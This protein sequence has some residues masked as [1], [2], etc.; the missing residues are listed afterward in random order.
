MPTTAQPTRP[1]PHGSTTA[2]R[3]PRRAVTTGLAAVTA[4]GL[5]AGCSLGGQGDGSDQESSSPSQGSGDGASDGDLEGRTV[6]LVTH[7]SFNP[8]KGA[9]KEFTKDTGITVKVLKSGDAGALTNKL[10]L[11]KEKPLGDVVFGIDNTFGGRAL[12]EGVVAEHG[13]SLPQGVDRHTIETDGGARL[14]P[15]DY[16]DV[17]VNVDDTWFEKKGVNPPQGLDDLTK[18]GYKGLF[19]TPGAATSSPGLAFLLATIGA[20]GDDGWEQYWKDLVAN[21]AKIT[22]GW[23]DAYTVDFTAGG[24]KGDRPIVLSYASSPPFTVPEGG[25]EPTT[26]ALLDTCFRQVEYA[27]VLEG[28]EE[29]EAGAKLVEYLLGKD[30]Q[31]GLPESMYVYP[32]RSDVE[33]PAEWEKWAPSAKEPIEVDAARIQEHREEWLTRWSEAT[34]Q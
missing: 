32:V 8:P 5:L 13:V 7:D 17:C 12:A 33:L 6:T 1:S 31:A 21:D 20:K 28:A 27:G 29:P 14:A 23:E 3:A 30:F 15:V 9:L 18:P 11:T 4:L 24:G 34:G 16:G 2:V 25:K 22:A 10:V 26:S 19:V